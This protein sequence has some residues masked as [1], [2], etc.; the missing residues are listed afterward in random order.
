L[1]GD[2]VSSII[3]AIGQSTA[4]VF[5]RE[6]RDQPSYAVVAVPERQRRGPERRDT[7]VCDQSGNGRTVDRIEIVIDAR[8]VRPR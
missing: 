1:T 5:A 8:R 2:F 4:L 6:Y 7:F 3:I